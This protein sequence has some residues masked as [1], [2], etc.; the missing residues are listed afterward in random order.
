MADIWV[1]DL[2]CLAHYV[3][4]N[5]HQFP[6]DFL[7]YFCQWLLQNHTLLNHRF[8]PRAN[9][10]WVG[11]LFLSLQRKV[12]LF[13]MN[14]FLCQLHILIFPLSFEH[15][16]LQNWSTCAHDPRLTQSVLLNDS[17]ILKH[18]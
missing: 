6:V 1:T 7:P 18:F 2:Q 16:S 4:F 10:F 8:S 17:L 14:S 3:L 5:S 12:K 11:T 9:F 15:L 13:G